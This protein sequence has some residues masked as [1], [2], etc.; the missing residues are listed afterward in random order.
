MTRVGTVMLARLGFVPST[1]PISPAGSDLVT[2]EVSA[3][4]LGRARR[5]GVPPR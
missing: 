2:V 3:M 1:C 4:P 5:S